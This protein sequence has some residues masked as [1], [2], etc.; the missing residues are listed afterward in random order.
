MRAPSQEARQ[1]TDAELP[2]RSPPYVVGIGASAGGLEA[3]ECFFDNVPPDVG[4]AFVVIQ[5][6]SPDFRSLMDE[7][8]ARRTKLPIHLV[9]DGMLVEPNCIYLIPPKKEMIISAGR[10]LLSER[11][12]AVD[13]S[14]PID[15]FFKSLAQDCGS[16]AIA[17]V[18]SGGGTDG[19]RGIRAV[20]DAGGLVLVQDEDTAQFNGMPRTARDVGV[21]DWV[22][23]PQ[24]MP[25]VLLEHARAWGSG[26]EARGNG[27]Q[28]GMSAVYR[29]LEDEFGID[30]THYKPSTVTRRIERRLQLSRVDDIGAYVQRLEKERD[31]LD[32]L[33]RDLLIGVTRFFRN[34]EVFS[35]L[36]QRILPEL[37]ARE[38][39]APFR[40]WVAGC[41]TGEEVYS[42]AILLHELAPRFGD[43]VVKIF[44]TDVHHGSLE[45]A[46]RGLYG[47][48]AIVNVTPERLER[49]FL[50]RGNQ[51]QVVPEIRQ[52]VV[53]APHNVI[54]D[55]PFTRVDLVSCRNLLIYL[56][57]AAQ[58]R[59]L[60]FFHFALNRGGM[61]VL[62]PSESPG[63]MVRDFET[64][65]KHWRIYR[66]HTDLR[67]QVETHV[68]VRG[69]RQTQPVS[70]A[71]PVIP[72]SS[73]AHLLGTYDALLEERMPPS[74]LLSDR[75]ELVHSFA[76]ASRFLRVRDGRVGLDA[77][78]M[79][80]GDLTLGL[81]AGV[82][83]ALKDAAPVVYSGVR[84]QSDEGEATYQCTIRRIL[85]RGA[86]VPYVLAS[87]E[88]GVRT[89]AAP[90]IASTEVDL[91]QVS[92]ER[93]DAVEVEA[94][95]T[96]RRACRPRR[97]S[98]TPATRSC[99][100]PTRSCSPPTR[101][102][103]APTRSCRA[104]TR[105][106]TR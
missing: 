66:K 27:D 13:L 89:E 84:D 81:P 63:N 6:L 65:D 2:P 61:V 95:P 25:R 106:S 14:L 59:A 35:V 99:R 41:A 74:L 57:P 5:H 52:M 22:L 93:L 55:A 67:T 15:V 91:R 90:R 77:V 12:R 32:V 100:R 36:E 76:G 10:L 1:S 80:D 88:S 39:H 64:V 73:V 19:S 53:F 46:T 9:E 85:A 102:C 79:V 30:F 87:F 11:G 72:R 68:P 70:G 29:M 58:Q 28:H 31:E 83:R 33:Y 50:R 103:R 101:S 97:R 94:P 45:H 71:A 69:G 75:G 47:D 4:M 40:V 34:P 7:I 54:K 49:Y 86:T 56:Q 18:L 17:I 21:A 43:R 20:H 8:L 23:P 62:G 24:E 51:Y 42:L 78:D 92:R 96:P 60:S 98:S 105:S 38:T 44:A 3:L 104:S 82:P 48:D 16:R 37:L 26:S